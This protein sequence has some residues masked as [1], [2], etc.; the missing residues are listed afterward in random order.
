MKLFLLGTGASVSDPHR[1]V[2]M[3]AV[4]G[5]VSGGRISTIVIDCGGDVI[6]RLLEVGVDLETIERVIVT[7]EHPDHASGF[8][9]MMQKL[10]LSGRREPV[11]VHGIAGALAQARRVLD[12]FDIE[13]WKEQGFPDIHW[14]EFAHEQDAEVFAS[15]TWRITSAP[16]DHPVPTA[17]FRIEHVPSGRILAY[18]CDTAPYDPIVD[19]SRGAHILVHE[20]NGSMPGVHSSAE[21][22]AD[23]A[24]RADV[25]RLILVHLPPGLSDAD[26]EEAR[27]TFERTELGQELGEYEV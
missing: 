4:Q 19:L 17:A 12:A 26:L 10:W 11:P 22:A 24:T 14:K 7:H 5:E 9:L 23:I 21:E 16:A 3:L 18:S 25:E 8:T 15:D 1:T 2:T 6:Q 13:G 20:A 27:K